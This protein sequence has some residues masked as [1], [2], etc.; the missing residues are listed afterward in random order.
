MYCYGEQD[1]YRYLIMERLEKDLVAVAK[2]SPAC[3]TVGDIGVQLLDGCEDNHCNIPNVS[4]TLEQ[5]YI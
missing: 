5:T 1:G 2:E 4:I 3:S